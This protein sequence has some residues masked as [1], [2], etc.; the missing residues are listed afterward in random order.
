MGLALS[1]PPAAY[2]V[3]KGGKKNKKWRRKWK[4][5]LR[6]APFQFAIVLSG[7]EPS[8]RYRLPPQK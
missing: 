1:A 7:F 3:L 8:S 4:K 6:A 2:P 5:E